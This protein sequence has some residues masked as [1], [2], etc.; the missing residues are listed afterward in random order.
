MEERRPET[1]EIAPEILRFPGQPLRRYIIRRA[2]DFPLGLRVLLRQQRETE[3]HDLRVVRVGEKN[4][5][6]LDVAMHQASGE[7]RLQALRHLEADLQHPQLRDALLVLDPIIQAP[8][9]HQLHHDVELPVIPPDREHLHHM[10]M[11]DRRRDSRFILE[12]LGKR[13]VA[14]K[15]PPEQL[16]RDEP[17]QP[18][19]A[20]LEDRA[21]PARPERLDHL[22]V[23][24]DT[25]HPHLRAAARAIELGKRLEPLRLDESP[26]TRTRLRGRAVAL[27]HWRDSNTPRERGNQR[28]PIGSPLSPTLTLHLHLQP[29]LFRGV[30]VQV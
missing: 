15:L 14:G 2:P 1:V 27:G 30:L 28:R 13:L 17:M 21:H 11:L 7:R 8:A 20:R 24:K 18:Q 12:L 29:H 4:V 9:I 26:A 22:V 16:Q 19:I 25:L 23:L 6:R 10:R 5:P 3:V